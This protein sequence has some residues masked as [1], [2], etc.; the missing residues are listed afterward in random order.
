M[1][2]PPVPS[3]SCQVTLEIFLCVDGTNGGEEIDEGVGED[4]GRGVKSMRVMGSQHPISPLAKTDLYNCLSNT[5][6]RASC[7][8]LFPLLGHARLHK[9]L[10]PGV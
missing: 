3:F 2:L 4:D 8:G 6:C 1:L 7:F 10:Q 9:V 5:T